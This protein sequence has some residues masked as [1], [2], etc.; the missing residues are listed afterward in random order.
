MP[1]PASYNNFQDTILY[2]HDEL[3]VVKVYEALTAKE[4]MRQMVNSE[5]AAGLSGEALNVRVRSEQK[6]S[7]SGGKEKGNQ[8]GRS[9]SKEP[10]DELFCRYYKRK[11]IIVRTVGNCRTR[12]RG[13]TRRSQRVKLLVV[14]LIIVLIMVIFLLL[15]LD[16]LLND[17][18]WILDSACSYHVCINRDLFSIM[19]RCK[20]EVLFEW[21]IILLVKLL[22][23]APC[24]S[25]CL[26]GLFTH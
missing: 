26:M 6:M 25:R 4:K 24:R 23:W 22:A 17:A 13:M 3:I 1:L 19:N 15:L 14:P 11:I 12:R 20:M 7:N 2:S 9:K 10:S 18:L 5:D 16:V 21:A 8:K